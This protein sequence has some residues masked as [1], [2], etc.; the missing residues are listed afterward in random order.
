[1]R[2]LIHLLKV[3]AGIDTPH[4]QLTNRELGVL[5]KYSRDCAT[6][7]EIGCYEGKTSVAF[8]INTRGAVYTVDPF[9]AGRAGICYGRWI[10]RVHAWRHHAGNL[11]F[12]KAYSVDA[13]AKVSEP[14]DLVFIDADHRF[15]A[16]RQDVQAWLPKLRDGGILALHDCKVT[17]A[18][19]ARLGSTDF[20]EQVVPTISE[21]REI[22]GVDSLVIFRVDRAHAS[23]PPGTLS[24][25]PS[26]ADALAGSA[27]PGRKV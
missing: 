19:P 27:G 8:A 7:Y 12:L 25:A 14:V 9:F 13:A 22:D 20:Y 15:E 17:A 6:I 16:V 5:L 4:S 24:H 21:L 11:R 2:T 10:A 18:S 1:M 3:V 23:R 26:A